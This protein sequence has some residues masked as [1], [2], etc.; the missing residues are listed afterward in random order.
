MGV[1]NTVHE[2]TWFLPKP[3]YDALKGLQE[4]VTLPSGNPRWGSVE[5]L[6]CHLLAI[7]A[8]EAYKEIR[9]KQRT[10]RMVLLPEE[11]PK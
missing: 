7:A 2:I 5:A 11:L 6:G 10:E 9:A 8:R 1:L 4:G 3:L